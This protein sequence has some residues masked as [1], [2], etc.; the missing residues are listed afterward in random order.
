MSEKAE[1]KQRY[2]KCGQ[3][4]KY[5]GISRRLLTQLTADGRI[6]ASRIS[7]RCTLYSI[8]ALEDFVA[9]HTIGDL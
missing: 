6:K 7:T 9:D 8:T 5:L 2:L 3:A 4:A 1:I